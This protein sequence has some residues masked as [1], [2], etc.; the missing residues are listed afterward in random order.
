MLASPDTIFDVLDSAFS[1]VG[2]MYFQR[3]M[4]N[5]LTDK[6]MIA[7]D[8][9]IGEPNA[10]HDVFAFTVFPHYQEFPAALAAIDAKLPR[11]LKNTKVLTDEM[12]AFLR[13]TRR[14]HFCFLVEKGRYKSTSIEMARTAIAAAIEHVR[15]LE[16]DG[17]EGGEGRRAGYIKAFKV[18]QE[19]AKAKRFNYR[20]FF[21][22]KILSVLSAAIM[23]WIIRHGECRQLALLPDR[24][25]MTAGCKGIF[26][27]VTE[28][29]HNG[30]CQRLGL[31]PARSI[32]MPSQEA[33]EGPNLFYDALVRVPD[34]VAGVV[35]RLDYREKVVTSDQVKH[36]ELVERFL[37]DNPNLL[38]IQMSETIVSLGASTIRLSSGFNPF[39]H[40]L[41][42]ELVDFIAAKARGYWSSPSPSY[43]RELLGHTSDYPL[44]SKMLRS[45][46]R[47]V[48]ADNPGC[49]RVFTGRS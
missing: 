34:Y 3:F 48:A 49:V 16:T 29:D 11:D 5:T 1:S 17:V 28:L 23:L 38:I 41:P 37:S 33:L 35:S 40:V 46:L 27:V 42:E 6:W 18:L 47:G 19:E 43:L 12:V 2:E 21:D 20:N 14:F 31:Q 45:L 44:V 39:P 8:F 7:A 10:A 30:L 22:I 24:D 36:K 13:D 4:R 9:V 25:K 32:G 26:R 15:R